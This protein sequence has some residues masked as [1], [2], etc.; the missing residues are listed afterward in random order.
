MTAP[1]GIV[2]NECEL[3]YANGWTA[4]GLLPPGSRRPGLRPC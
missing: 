2:S 1:Y 3:T 4:D